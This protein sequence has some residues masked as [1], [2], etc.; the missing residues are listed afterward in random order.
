MRR[1]VKR[2]S[3][4]CRQARRLGCER[5]GLVLSEQFD[6]VS[7][8]LVHGCFL[9]QQGGLRHDTV[10]V[11]FLS[12]P[13]DTHYAQFA[14]WFETHEVGTV[15]TADGALVTRARAD[16]HRALWLGLG[17]AGAP[18]DGG[19]DDASSDV[20]SAVVDCVVDKMR[21]FEKGMRGSTRVHL[22]KSV[23]VEPRGAVDEPVRAIA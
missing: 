23:W 5:L 6:A 3:N 16:G 17:A 11:C 22:L 15:M 2:S 4:T 14:E 20:G 8:G 12:G 1:A 7:N 10:P 19:L 21:H 13:A 9:R 18:F